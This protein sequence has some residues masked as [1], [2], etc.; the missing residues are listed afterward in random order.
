MQ[1]ARCAT[2]P[3]VAFSDSEADVLTPSAKPVATAL[4]ASDAAASLISQGSGAAPPGTPGG[5]SVTLYNAVKLAARQPLDPSPDNTRPG[6]QYYLFAA[7]NSR[8]CALAAKDARTPAI[9]ST[10]CLLSGPA[11]SV[12]DLR[13]DG[14]PASVPRRASYS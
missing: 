8:A 9:A 5:G 12:A 13:R 3:T 1:N 7:P 6:S 10:H 2:P 4:Q 11:D 14:P